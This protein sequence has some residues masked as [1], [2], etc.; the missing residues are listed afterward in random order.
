MDMVWHQQIETRIE[1]L[2]GRAGMP[3][4]QLADRVGVG[5]S[6]IARIETGTDR[7][8]ADMEPLLPI[9][10]RIRGW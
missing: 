4:Q 3:Q 9:A 1:R 7:D 10:T 5:A 2:R 6:Y 8:D